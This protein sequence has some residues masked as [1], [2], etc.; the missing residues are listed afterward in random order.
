MKNGRAAVLAALVSAAA[1]LLR[2]FSPACFAA[3]MSSIADTYVLMK[4][5]DRD[6]LTLRRVRLY[7]VASVSA[8]SGKTLFTLAFSFAAGLVPYALR[9]TGGFP[10]YA[11]VSAFMAG[12]PALQAEGYRAFAAL[13]PMVLISAALTVAAY[14]RENK[15]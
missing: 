7:A 3:G 13:T 6:A 10:L 8:L 5:G 9:R 11:D 14:I 1:L 2:L 4:D 12:N 15:G